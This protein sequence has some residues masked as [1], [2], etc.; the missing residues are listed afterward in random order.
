[1][2]Q[3][4]LRKDVNRFASEN[5]NLGKHVDHIKVKV[6]MVQETEQ[7]LKDVTKDQDL[8]VKKLIETVQQNK[9]ILDA[10][11]KTILL[12]IEEDLMEVLLKSD[13]D[14]SGDY[15]EREIKR[16]EIYMRG[17][18][19]VEVNE[20]LLRKAIQNKNAIVS[21]MNLV[22]DIGLEGLQ[23]GDRIFA[24]DTDNEELQA[25]ILEEV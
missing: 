25:K 11:R 7:R 3:N 1:M 21:I 20:A 17:L 10:K 22:R 12:G 18:P 23:E 6:F 13:R 4:K 14:D 8:N 15:T 2:V 5:L 19:A 9:A 24:I 16:M